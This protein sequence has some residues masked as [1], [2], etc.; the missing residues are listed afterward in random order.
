MLWFL[1]T[2]SAL[3]VTGNYAKTVKVSVYYETLCPASELFFTEQL[4]PNYDELKSIMNLE[5]IPF[6]KANITEKDGKLSF[7]C[8]HGP[9][10]CYGN[11]VHSCA[12]DLAQGEQGI[13]FAMCSMESY[14]ATADQFL[15]KCAADNN[16]SW[17]EI[18]NCL[19]SGKADELLAAN[20][21][22]TYSLKPK[23]AH[24]PTVVLDNKFQERISSIALNA[25]DK[26]VNFILNDSKC[27]W[28]NK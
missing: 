5:L 25:L 3:F 10:E 16:I 6:G 18:Q 11:K 23:L 12:L 17:D 20:G 21:K 9:D 14:D 26:L 2:L 19:K 1:F 27:Y 7:T 15:K 13:R 24:V 8:Q 28:C 22:K 4:N